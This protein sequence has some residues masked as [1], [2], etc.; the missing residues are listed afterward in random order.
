M[1]YIILAQGIIDCILVAT[2]KN[3]KRDIKHESN[4]HM[5]LK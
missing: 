2:I 5:V 1:I 4:R 3:I